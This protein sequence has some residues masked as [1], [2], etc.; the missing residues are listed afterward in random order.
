MNKISK[1]INSFIK[2]HEGYRS[3]NDTRSNEDIQGLYQ[4]LEKVI[5]ETGVLKK[6]PH[7]RIKP[8]LGS[9]RVP[10]KPIIYFFDSRETITG[11]KGVYVAMILP[12]LQ[13]EKIS[14]ILKKGLS[15]P[16]LTIT[17]TQGERTLEKEL[18]SKKDA[19][20]ALSENA[21][22][23]ADTYNQLLNDSAYSLASRNSQ[24]KIRI[25]ERVYSTSR[26]ASDKSI[27][28]AIDNMLTVLSVYCEHNKEINNLS[29][30]K[31]RW[32]QQQSR[33]GQS[34]FKS[35]LLLSRK[36]CMVTGATTASILDACHV[37]PHS[38][39]V[40][41]SYENGLLLRKDIHK[42]YDDKLIGFDANG[43]INIS[44]KVCKD[45]IMYTQ[46]DGKK[47]S[48]DICEQLSCNLDQKYKEYLEFNS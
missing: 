12:Q 10:V 8:S 39:R 33:Q 14:K 4:S 26:G 46:Y 42:L 2:S 19:L 47:L 25:A 3:D 31:K 11:T 17:L 29:E 45:D 16:F 22:S 43:L 7:I 38:I 27:A 21:I 48:G 34:K 1:C 37:I 18:S 28:K 6:Y 40:N 24:M 41:Y 15:N 20:A 35:L 32:V 23:L 44:S 5:T 13:E 30:D 9:G 36:K